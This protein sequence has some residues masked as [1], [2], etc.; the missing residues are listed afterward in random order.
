MRHKG[1]PEHKLP[2]AV[3]NEEYIGKHHRLAMGQDFDQHV[4][5]NELPADKLAK[6]EGHLYGPAKGRGKAEGDSCEGLAKGPSKA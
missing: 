5:H 2:F 6:G 1:M 4:E 3:K